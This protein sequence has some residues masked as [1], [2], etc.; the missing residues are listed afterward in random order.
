MTTEVPFVST[1]IEARAAK[2][3]GVCVVAEKSGVVKYADANRI[4]IN[5][6]VYELRKFDRSNAGTCVNQRPLIAK[7]DKVKAGDVIA[8]GMATKDGHLSLGKMS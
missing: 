7:G 6:D 5:D 1:G 4:T 2:D 8:D 3:S